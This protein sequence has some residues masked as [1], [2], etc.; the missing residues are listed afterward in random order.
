ML[1]LLIES[2][3]SVGVFVTL[4][5]L[6]LAENVKLA[7]HCICILIFTSLFNVIPELIIIISDFFARQ[8]FRGKCKQVSKQNIHSEKL[9]YGT[10]K[11]ADLYILQLQI[12]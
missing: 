10:N 5:Y 11:R 12:C 9:H 3:I 8:H 6:L 4:K 1:I 7:G 2:R